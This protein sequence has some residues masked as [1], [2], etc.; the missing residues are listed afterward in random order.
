MM[1]LMGTNGIREKILNLFHNGTTPFTA[2]GYY[3][4]SG[5]VVFGVSLIVAVIFDFIYNK[6]EC[7]IRNI[8]KIISEGK[9]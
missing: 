4:F 8:L 3:V 5:G 9:K 6:V 7:K 1:I 2:L